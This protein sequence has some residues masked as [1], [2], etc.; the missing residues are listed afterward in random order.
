M[1]ATVRTAR[2]RRPAVVIYDKYVGVQTARRYVYD[3]R[4]GDRLTWFLTR[5]GMQQGRRVRI[6]TAVRTTRRRANRS[7]RTD[8]PWH[9][10]A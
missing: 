7:T 6:I 4:S 3:Y 9:S 10:A 1:G 8:W 5:I 2:G